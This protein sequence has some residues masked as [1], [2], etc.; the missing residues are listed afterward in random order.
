MKIACVIPHY[1]H[2]ATVLKVASGGRKHLDDV[3]VVDDGSSDLPEDFAAR[4]AALGVALIRHERNLGKGAALLTAARELAADGV[5]HMIAIDAD[6]QHD[7]DDLPR[8]VAEI[9]KPAQIGII[10]HRFGHSRPRSQK[11]SLCVA[12]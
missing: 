9:E 5:T 6:G 3:R 10:D 8:F 7:P 11:E 4:L 2:P 12:V 1:N